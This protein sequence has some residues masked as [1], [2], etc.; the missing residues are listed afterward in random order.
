[1]GRGSVEI[2]FPLLPWG[3][4][5]GFQFCVSILKGEES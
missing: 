4:G 3:G 2:I 5:G 1:M